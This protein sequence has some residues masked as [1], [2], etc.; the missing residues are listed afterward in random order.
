M[1]NL[2]FKYGRK[3]KKWDDRLLMRSVIFCIVLS[4]AAS[5]V[6]LN[7]VQISVPVSESPLVSRIASILLFSVMVTVAVIGIASRIP[8]IRENMENRQLLARMLIDNAWY[9]TDVNSNSKGVQDILYRPHVYFWRRHNIIYFPGMYYK[10]RDD[11]IFITVKIDMGKY[12]ER[13][14]HLE[15]KIETGLDC[16]IVNVDYRR[17]WMHYEFICDVATRRITVEQMTVENG[18]MRFMDHIKW[19]YSRHPHALIVGDTGSGKTLFL[20]S[21]IETLLRT[22]AVLSIIDAKNASIAGLERVLPDVHYMIEDIGVCIG[23]FYDDMM[24]RMAEIKAKSGDK[25]ENDYRD[26]GMRPHFLIIDEYVA[27]LEMFPKKEWEDIVSLM[28]KIVLLGRQAGFFLMLTCQ[29]PDAKYLPDGMRAQFGLR[30]ALGKLD[31]N[32]YTMVFG[33]SDKNFV[34]KDIKGRG[35]AGLWNGVITEFYAPYVTPG[36]SFL[37]SIKAAYISG[38][39]SA[40]TP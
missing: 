40:G 8:G 37:K 20:L 15:T 27:Y 4:M 34:Q 6:L 32:G 21:I 24:E 7:Y 38:E 31:S 14:L 30:V 18:C 17:K 29:R 3:I 2:F 11:K 39:T 1:K 26:C 23:K 16:E 13:L 10:K 36:H 33:S 9:E 25:L 5:A 28:K 22:G 19:D 35:Y 12:Q